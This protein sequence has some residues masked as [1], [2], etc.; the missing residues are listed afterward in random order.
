MPESEA[1][2]VGELYNRRAAAFDARRPEAPILEKPWLDRLIAL[3]KPGGR[4]LD[5]GCGAGRPNAGYLIGC[6][7][8]VDGVDIAPA[9]IALARS[10]WPDQIWRIGDMREAALNG[11]YAAAL[12]WHSSFHLPAKDQAAFIARVSRALSPG[13][14]FLFTSGDCEGVVWGEMDG[15]P[16]FHA[17]LDPADTDDALRTAGFALVERRLRDPAC[18]GASVWLARK[19]QT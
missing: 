14:P 1:E 12:A 13:A 18:G 9:M 3:C 19:A 16:L 8:G 4:V 7:L 6:G 15:A 11:P 2:N 10:R 5:L 17:S